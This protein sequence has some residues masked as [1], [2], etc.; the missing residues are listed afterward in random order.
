MNNQNS[1]LNELITALRTKPDS[2]LVFSFEGQTI[3]SGYHVTEVKHAAMNSLDC[4]NGKDQWQEVIIQLMDGS[5]VFKGKHMSCGKFMAIFDKA[6]ESLAF[7]EN[8][9]TF[10][11]FAPNNVGLRKLVI[12]TIE[13]KEEQVLVHLSSPTAVCKPYLQAIASKLA[14]PSSNS[15]CETD[16]P[17]PLRTVN[18]SCCN[19]TNEA[20]SRSTC[21]S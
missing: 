9:L 4:G 16:K 2:P 12:D 20:K 7:D 11:E 3:H 6:I 8:T 19:G 18:Q 15:C 5:A 14:E 1:N 21:C 10:I 17:S 13:H